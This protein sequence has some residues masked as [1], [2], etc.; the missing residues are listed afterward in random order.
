MELKRITSENEFTFYNTISYIC[1][2]FLKCYLC[3]YSVEISKSYLE[4][5]LV[6]IKDLFRKNNIIFEFLYLLILV[7]YS[8]L[9]GEV[10]KFVYIDL[11]SFECIKF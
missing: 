10:S 6:K 3:Y 7:F 2:I 11:V 5:L 8:I 1:L 4:K 9:V